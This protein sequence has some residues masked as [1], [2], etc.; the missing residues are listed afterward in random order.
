MPAYDYACECGR[1]AEL[2]VSVEE[3][4]QQ[5]CECGKP[6]KRVLC[7]PL[8]VTWSGKFHSPWAKKESGE[9]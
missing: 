7:N 3:R 5:K 6:L 1:T 9:W 2:R 4:D 8:T